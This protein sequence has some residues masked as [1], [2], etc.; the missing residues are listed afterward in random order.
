[1]GTGLGEVLP[2]MDRLIVN[3]EVCMKSMSRITRSTKHGNDS[4]NIFFFVFLLFSYYE[5][6]ILP[7]LFG[8]RGCNLMSASWPIPSCLLG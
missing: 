1:M 7:M 2:C 6:A 5:T 8:G 4:L 3:S